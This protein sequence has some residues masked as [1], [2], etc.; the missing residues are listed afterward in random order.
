MNHGMLHVF[1]SLELYYGK[2]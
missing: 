2:L 1:W